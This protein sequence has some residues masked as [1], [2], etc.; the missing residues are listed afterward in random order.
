MFIFK[1]KGT[2]EIVRLDHNRMIHANI[3]SVMHLHATKHLMI[4]MHLKSFVCDVRQIPVE[5]QE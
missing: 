1:K 5:Q 2:Y 3:P 4:R